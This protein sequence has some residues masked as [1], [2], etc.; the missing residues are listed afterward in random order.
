[1]RGLEV[2]AEQAVAVGSRARAAAARLD[3]EQVVEQRHHEVV[4]EEAVAVPDQEGDDRQPRRREAAEQPEI[5][6]LPPALERALDEAPLERLDGAAA[7]RLL[8][9][10]DQ[11]GADRLEDRRRAPLLAVLRRPA[12]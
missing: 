5:R 9:M 11:P 10:E 4:V 3:A 7:D 1:M 12:R 2:D 8:E 6:V